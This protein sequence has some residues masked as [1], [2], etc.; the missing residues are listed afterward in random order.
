MSVRNFVGVLGRSLALG[1]AAVFLLAVIAIGTALV[2]LA[3]SV[4]L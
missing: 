1:L 4:V 3:L 2:V